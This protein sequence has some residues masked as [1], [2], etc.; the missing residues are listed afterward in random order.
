MRAVHF[1]EAKRLELLDVPE[2][3]PRDGQA[4]IEVAACGICGSDLSCFKTGVFAPTVLGHELSGIVVGGD[5]E[6]GARVVVDP[7]QPCGACDECA[8]GTSHRCTQALTDGLGQTVPGGFAERVVAP[9]ANLHL[10]PDDLTLEAAALAEPLAVALHGLDLARAAAEPT[11]VFGLGPIGLLTIAALRD[12]G[13]PMI[14]GVDPAE[15][16]RVL[17]ARMGATHAVAP[18]DPILHDARASLVVEASGHPS[19]LTDAGNAAAPGARVLLLGIPMSEA[20]IWPM[21]WITKELHVLGSIGQS[22]GDF[23]AALTLLAR[24]PA[25]AAIIT[26]RIGLDAVPA[27]FE[28]LIA[29]PDAGKVLAVP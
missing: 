29:A 18:G 13:A 22:A 21:V 15:Q 7:K 14:I 8:N 16:R 6:H 5:F 12:R 19:A 10:V 23:V 2:P 28:Q 24:A 17:A 4:L 25:I 27:M 20:T 9:A 26:A 1:P 11:V 3:T